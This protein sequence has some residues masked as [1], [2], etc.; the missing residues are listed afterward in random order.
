MRL[1]IDI[2]LWCL[3]AACAALVLAAA[4]AQA[5]WLSKLS[6]EMGMAGAK[7]ARSGGRGLEQAASHLRAL[8]ATAGAGALAAHATPEGHWRFANRAG[9]V[10]T[11]GTPA[12][13]KRVVPTLL[14]R[15]QPARASSR[16]TSPRT[17][18]SAS[19]RF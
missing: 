1:A 10:F 5:N 2:G 11:A 7:V 16:S 19:A 14:P 17:R 18:C 12:E 3:R 9:D 6:G 8:P 4:P 15:C 13:L